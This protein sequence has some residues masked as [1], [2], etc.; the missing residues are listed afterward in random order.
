MKIPSLLGVSVLSI[1]LGSASFSQGGAF[2]ATWELNGDLAVDDPSP[3]EGVTVSELVDLEPDMEDGSMELAATALTLNRAGALGSG[4]NAWAFRND[5][6]SSSLFFLEFKVTNESG[7]EVTV[8]GLSL[9]Q[10]RGNL[11]AFELFDQNG[12]ALTELTNS[13]P[14][15]GE[16]QAIL[17]SPFKIPAGDSAMFRIDFNSGSF[18]SVHSIDLIRV[19]GTVVE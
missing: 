14:A 2:V 10:S 7:K 6:E 17:N 4:V 11:L 1:L 15:E 19:S 18:D 5:S 12:V 8:D 13:I 16:V 3:A 9:L